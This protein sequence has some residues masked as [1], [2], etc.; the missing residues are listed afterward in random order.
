MYTNKGCSDRSLHLSH[1]P[2]CMCVLFAGDGTDAALQHASNR[3]VEEQAD[4]GENQ[5]AQDSAQRGQDPHG[6]V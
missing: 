6:H 3:G 2:V 1:P 5:T 4:A